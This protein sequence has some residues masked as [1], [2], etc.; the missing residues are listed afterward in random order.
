[1]EWERT[2]NKLDVSL[3]EALAWPSVGAE[4]QYSVPYAVGV[5]KV[6]DNRT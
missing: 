5:E 2:E 6:G 4:T 3:G 1:M